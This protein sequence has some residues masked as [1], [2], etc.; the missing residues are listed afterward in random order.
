[1]SESAEQGS[2]KSSDKNNSKDYRYLV[3]IGRFQ[4]F[5][6][7]HKAVVD[8]ALKRADNVIMLIGSANLPRSLRNPFSVDERA[9]MIKNAYSPVEAAR[10][11]MLRYLGVF[12]KRMRPEV[13]HDLEMHY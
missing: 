11:L 13:A 12:L 5:H 8:E 9:T 6:C 10:I 4:P 3:F 1:M 2:D 7:G